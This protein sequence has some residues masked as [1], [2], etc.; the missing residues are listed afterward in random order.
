MKFMIALEIKKKDINMR[1]TVK[2]GLEMCGEVWTLLTLKVILLLNY[3]QVYVLTTSLYCCLI[4]LGLKWIMC[5]LELLHFNHVFRRLTFLATLLAWAMSSLILMMLVV[6]LLTGFFSS[7]TLSLLSSSGTSTFRLSTAKQ[8]IRKRQFQHDA[9]NNIPS[10]Q[11]IEWLAGLIH[12][13]RFNS[14]WLLIII[15]T[16]KIHVCC[17][18]SDTCFSGRGNS[19]FISSCRVIIVSHVFGPFLN[20]VANGHDGLKDLCWVVERALGHLQGELQ[21]LWCSIWKRMQRMKERKF[22]NS[23]TGFCNM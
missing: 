12:D 10:V 23:T 6:T 19:L 15:E 16:S 18:E 1:C 3:T 20:L 17:P 2:K 22:W 7:T 13:E 11:E 21:S 14:N 8:F 9:F 5:L 4:L